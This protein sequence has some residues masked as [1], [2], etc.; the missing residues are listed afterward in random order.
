MDI[1]DFFTIAD[2][3]ARYDL[4]DIQTKYYLESCVSVRVG[5][6]KFYDIMKVNVYAIEGKL[7]C[8]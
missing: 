1:N 3:D 2:I 7:K 8:R 5:S 6:Q 4:A